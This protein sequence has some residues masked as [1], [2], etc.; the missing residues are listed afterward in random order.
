[1]GGSVDDEMGPLLAYQRTVPETCPEMSWDA[2]DVHAQEETR[3]TAVSALLLISILCE[4]KKKL[5]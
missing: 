4:N 3:Q 5:C 2:V 1:M